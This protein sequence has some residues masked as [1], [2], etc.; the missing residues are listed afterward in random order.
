[1]GGDADA[2]AGADLPEMNAAEGMVMEPA[3]RVVCLKYER[4]MLLS[5]A[6]QSLAAIFLGA[7]ARAA[8]VVL[9]RGF[10]TLQAVRKAAVPKG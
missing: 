6:S 1:V 8:I 3:G 10:A 9:L 7:C 4:N 2:D 5:L